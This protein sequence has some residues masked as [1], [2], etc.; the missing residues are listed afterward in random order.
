M[1]L[2][3]QV[4][5]IIAK[6]LRSVEALAT[7]VAG[8]TAALPPDQL[9]R[10]CR[11]LGPSGTPCWNCS[12]RAMRRATTAPG[13]LSLRRHAAPAGRP[14]PD[15]AGFMNRTLTVERVTTGGTL[16]WRAWRESNPRPTA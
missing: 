12:G 9:E 1:D 14:R 5:E 6:I 10:H 15:P 16:R 11:D 2:W 7:Q 3:T 8:G 4:E 13:A